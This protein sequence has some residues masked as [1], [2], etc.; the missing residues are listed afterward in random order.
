MSTRK[1]LTLTAFGFVAIV[2]ALVVWQ[3]M[4]RDIDRVA[5]RMSVLDAKRSGILRYSSPDYA[6]GIIKAP[7]VPGRPEAQ[8]VVWRSQ[9]YGA[10]RRTLVVLRVKNQTLPDPDTWAVLLGDAWKKEYYEFWLL[11]TTGG[12]PRCLATAPVSEG[13][14]WLVLAWSPEGGWVYLLKSVSEHSPEVYALP[15]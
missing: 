14:S 15:L 4:P 13:T 12:K 1:K 11:S 8:V 2:T 9:T 10:V 5:R 3:A 6:L 7:V